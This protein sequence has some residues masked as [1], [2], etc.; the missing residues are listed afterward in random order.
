MYYQYKSVVIGFLALNNLSEE[1]FSEAI[2]TSE[3]MEKI[4]EQ[5]ENLLYKIEDKEAEIEN[6]KTQWVALGKELVSFFKDYPDFQEALDAYRWTNGSEKYI[7]KAA[8]SSL[9]IAE[10]YGEG[11]Y[12]KWF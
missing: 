8:E 9:K 4:K 5:K 7:K 3:K 10:V 12:D 2:L 1:N 11:D 6:L